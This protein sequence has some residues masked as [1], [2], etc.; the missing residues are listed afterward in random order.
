M[1]LYH[2][3]GR[4]VK[5]HEDYL[6]REAARH[7]TT[8]NIQYEDQIEVCKKHT[9]AAREQEKTARIIIDPQVW[10]T[11]YFKDHGTLWEEIP[12]FQ[13]PDPSEPIPEKGVDRATL[14][15][16][17]TYTDEY[18]RYH[19]D[20]VELH[21]PICYPRVHSC[22]QYQHRDDD[23][24]AYIRGDEIENYI[25][26]WLHEM[27]SHLQTIR[28]SKGKEKERPIVKY[29]KDEDGNISG[30]NP[31][32]DFEVPAVK[33]PK[34]LLEKIHLYNCML[35]LGLPSFIQRPLIDALVAEIY[36]TPLQEC[37]LEVLEMIVARFYSLGVAVL[38]PVLSHLVGTYAF[39]S[40][41]DRQHGRPEENADRNAAPDTTPSAEDLTPQ[42]VADDFKATENA[43][44]FSQSKRQLLTY[45]DH[46]GKRLKYPNDTF[47][48][49][50]KLPVLAHSIR[51]WSNVRANGSAAAATTGYPLNVGRVKK[52]YRRRAA[53]PICTQVRNRDWVEYGT[54][55]LKGDEEYQ[56]H[57]PGRGKG[58][59]G[60]K[61]VE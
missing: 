13:R 23:Q 9:P 2:A 44:D 26:P 17:S 41:E 51:H 1:V 14:M 16:C 29:R 61:P 45:S 50:P 39:R 28:G 60:E 37:H 32:F 4:V 20:E 7:A 11:L 48:L 46:P 3:N 52:Y 42:S 59:G 15:K 58:E 27:K 10:Y 54:Y 5:A 24:M 22:G 18:F 53:S 43:F 49:P 34:D 36:R 38:D 47:I 25:V 56:R 6:E 55:R 19:P 12:D 57:A 40:I 30:Y 33:I 8:P 35:Q 31:V 21:L